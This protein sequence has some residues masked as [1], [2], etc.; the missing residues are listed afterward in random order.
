MAFWTRL[1]MACA[2]ST[3]ARPPSAANAA[4]L[5]VSM[6]RGLPLAVMYRKPAQ[7]RNSADAVSPTWVATCNN[8]LK[9]SMMACGLLIE[10]PFGLGTKAWR[11]WTQNPTTGGEVGSP[12][13]AEDRLNGDD[14]ALSGR[15]D[16]L[17]ATDVDAD[18]RNPVARIGVGAGKEHQVARLELVLCHPVGGR[19]LELRGARER[20]TNLAENQLDQAGAVETGGRIGAAENVAHSQIATGDV[21]RPG[22]GQRR[23]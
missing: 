9:R 2:R 19:V 3:I 14:L 22:G 10:T 16:L 13:P 18:V 23:G 1:A 20:D 5:A 4:S 17:P 11:S 12:E 7:A 21:D 15:V 8:R 6:R